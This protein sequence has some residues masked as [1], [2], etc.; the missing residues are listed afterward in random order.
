MP[1]TLF[2]GKNHSYKN[3]LAVNEKHNL[4]NT[5][6]II[7]NSNNINKRHNLI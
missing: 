4:R 1:A 7:D 2:V 5:A 3:L 6:R